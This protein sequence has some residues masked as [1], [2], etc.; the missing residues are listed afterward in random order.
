MPR[1]IGMFGHDLDPRLLR[2]PARPTRTCCTSL[3]GVWLR[4]RDGVS[5]A[6]AGDPTDG[7]HDRPRAS[8]RCSAR[9]PSGCSYLAGKRLVDRAVGLLAA[10]LLAVAFLPVFYAHLALND[11][12]TLAPLCLA[13]SGAAGVLRDGRVRRL[14]CSRGSGSAWRARPSTRAGS[15][16]CRCS[17]R[18]W[19]V[20]GAG[21]RARAVARPAA[22]GRRWRSRLPRRQPVRAARLRRVPRRADA[23][24]PTASATAA[25]KLGLTQDNGLALLP[26]DARAGGWAGCPSLAGAR[27]RRAAGVRARRRRCCVLVPAPLAVRAFMG[28]QER[29]FGALAACR[30]SRSSACWPPTRRAARAGAAR[31]GAGA[32]PDARR[33]PSSRSAGRGSS[34]PCTTGMVLSRAGHPQRWRATGWSRT[35]RRARRSSWSRVVPDGWAQDVGDPSP[36]TPQRQPLDQVPDEA[37]E[38][39]QRRLDS[40][41]A[42]AHREH[43]G[44]RAHAAARASSTSTSAQGYCYVVTGSTQRGRAEAEPERRPEAIAYYRELERARP[45]RAISASPYRGGREAGALQ[46]RLLVRLLPA[47]LRRGPGRIMTSTGSTGGAMRGVVD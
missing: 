42:G 7:V 47:G 36:V 29:F 46:L 17:R 24:S 23:T 22:R 35:S 40:S 4:R 1:A 6:F 12:P 39:R 45:R 11:V 20:R 14:R 19:C 37:L 13:L 8:R 2:Q 27:R 10:A 31:A 16:C 21:G 43:R 26:L 5:E 15:C 30:C 28:T 44:L 25:G 33:S 38:P 3:F 34:T 32:A 9:S 18:R 41:R